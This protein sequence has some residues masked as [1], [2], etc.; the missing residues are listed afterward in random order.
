MK[1]LVLVLHEVTSIGMSVHSLLVALLVAE[2][3]LHV[4]AGEAEHDD[5]ADLNGD[6][7]EGTGGVSSEESDGGGDH[8]GAEEGGGVDH[9][10]VRVVVPVVA[11]DDGREELEDEL[12]VGG[13]EVAKED[14]V[15]DGADVGADTDAQ[16]GGVNLFESHA[17][18]GHEAEDG[19]TGNGQAG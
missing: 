19:K 4:V 11:A 3:V 2:L 14:C 7:A 17:T 18:V 9:E 12:G 5:A 8:V 13:G 10:L 16:D 15:A 6:V 1:F